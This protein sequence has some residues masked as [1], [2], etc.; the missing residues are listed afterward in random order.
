[1]AMILAA[2]VLAPLLAAPAAARVGAQHG[3]EA[4][5]LG[6]CGVSLL[7]AMVFG[8]ATSGACGCMGLVSVCVCVFERRPPDIH[9]RETP[10]KCV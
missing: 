8:A 10:C 2:C 4:M 3:P 6:S 7:T 1:M 9:H 5:I